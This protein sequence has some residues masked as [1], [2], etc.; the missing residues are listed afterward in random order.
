MIK[1]KKR[2]KKNNKIN[3]KNKN[4]E[5]FLNK[6]NNILPNFKNEL[7]NQT[8][9]N[10]HKIINSNSWFNINTYKSNKVYN[11]SNINTKF[12]NNVV[13]CIKIK[14]ILNDEQ[15]IIINKWLDAY[16]EMYNQALLYLRNSNNYLKNE[17][18]KKNINFVENNLINFYTLRNNLKNIKINIINKTQILSINRNT[19]I[20][21]HNLDYAVNLLLSNIKAAITNL[22]RNNIKRFR[23]KFWKNTR[24]SKTIDIEKCY[25]LNNKICPKILGDIKYEYNNKEYF[26]NNINNNVKINYNRI[27]NEYLLLIPKDNTPIEI[28]NKPRNIISLDP[29]LRTFMTGLTEDETIKIGTNVNKDIKKYVTRLNKINDNKKIPK[30]I[31]KKNEEMINRKIYNKVNDLHWKTIKFLVVNFKNILLGDMSAKGIVKKNSSVLDNE[32]KVACLRTR[33]YEF[34]QRLEY[35]C[36]L[37]KTNYK[38]VNEYYTSKTCSLCGNYKDDLQGEKIYECNKCNNKIDRDVNGC[39]NIFI[40]GISKI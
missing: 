2:K 28:Q 10:Q 39:R 30:K 16:T 25:I 14:M 11:N 33:F 24:L 1:N 8:Y 21:S 13:N 31:K 9:N 4:R 36:M 37:T 22:K 34:R 3:K 32:T 27:T 23:I 40:R 17:A 20:Q 38:L 29:G 12:Q 35:K 19:K 26:L 6:F 15:K 5:I 18:I 7:P